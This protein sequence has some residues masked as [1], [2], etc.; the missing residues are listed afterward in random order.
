[1]K[2]LIALILVAAMAI[3]ACVLFASCGEEDAV[4]VKVIDIALSEEYYGFAVKKGNTALQSS[5]NAYLAKI[6]ADG[7]LDAIMDKYLNKYSD[8]GTPAEITSATKDSTKDQLIVATSTGFEPFEMVDAG[9]YSGVDL[10]IA[11]GLAEYL[12][13]VAN[14][15]DA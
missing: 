1:M 3:S 12:G 8:N 5:V 15:D 11:A 7:T 13:R 9:K 10:E 4:K 6:K 2:K 14:L